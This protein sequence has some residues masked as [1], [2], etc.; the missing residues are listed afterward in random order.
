MRFK[1]E[2]VQNFPALLDY[3]GTITHRNIGRV[4]LP[5]PHTGPVSLHLRATKY[6][7]STIATHVNDLHKILKEEKKAACIILSDCGPDYSPSN[8]V[9]SLFYF[10]LLQELN[11]DLLS[12]ST[13]AARYSAYNTVEHAWS[14]LS[15][16]LAGVVFGPK[17]EGD[18]KPPCNQR[19]L[20]ANEIKEKEYAVFDKAISDL[21]HCWKN[22]EFNVYPVRI[23]AIICGVDNLK[24]GDYPTV[25]D[26][27]KVPL[28]DLHQYKDMKNECRSMFHHLDRHS[29]EVVFIR[30]KDRSCC[31]KWQ[32]SELRDHLAIFDFRLPA[33]VFGTFRGG[34]F[35]T[36]LQRLEEKGNGQK[37][38]DEGQPT[39]VANR[40]EKCSMCYIYKFKSKTEQKRYVGMFHRYAKSIYKEPDFE[41]WCVKSNLLVWQV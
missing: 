29:S 23:K 21:A 13:Y 20:S 34:H 15:N 2:N 33:P 39:A 4:H 11:F 14:H 35:D 36:F 32:S 1:I 18:S 25:K 3:K 26:F 16:L 17:L 41:C 6:H 8:V 40:L 10:R 31:T 37:Y 7:P 27:F 28:R 24:W 9:N 30:C 5:I 19:N 22:A 38:G 12:V